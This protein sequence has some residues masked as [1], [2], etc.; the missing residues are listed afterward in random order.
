LREPRGAANNFKRGGKMR[1]SWRNGFNFTRRRAI[2]RSFRGRANEQKQFNMPW[3]LP[4]ENFTAKHSKPP[5]RK[6]AIGAKPMNNTN[7]FVPQGSV[8]EQNKRRSRMKLAVF[9]VLTVSVCGLT[10]ML[11]QGCK[12]EV[13]SDNQ[14][15]MMDT[16]PPTMLDTNPP[17]AGTNPPVVMPPVETNP[18]AVVVPVAP[19]T[20]PTTGA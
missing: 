11:I 12:R 5:Q 7:P 20:P 13:A 18:P 8:L 2:Q 3:N 14:P 4:R 6:D 1:P 19:V 16:N 15:P 10:A 9:C 17:T